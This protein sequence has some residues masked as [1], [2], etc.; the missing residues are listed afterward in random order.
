MEGKI[1]RKIRII[2]PEIGWNFDCQ[3]TL[4]LIL[5]STRKLSPFEALNCEGCWG[6]KAK[7]IFS[8]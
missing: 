3:I 6:K 7:R 1:C 4:N 5:L 8:A 2:S